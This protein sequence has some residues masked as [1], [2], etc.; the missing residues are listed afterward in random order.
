MIVRAPL[1]AMYASMAA[2]PGRVSHVVSTADGCGP[3]GLERGLESPRSTIL[4][5]H[6]SLPRSSSTSRFTAGARPGF[7]L[8]PVGNERN[9]SLIRQDGKEGRWCPKNSGQA[10]FWSATAVLPR[11][12]AWPTAL[13]IGLRRRISSQSNNAGCP[14]QTKRSGRRPA[15][16]RDPSASSEVVAETGGGQTS[17]GPR[18]GCG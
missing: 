11:P 1:L 14:W 5:R 6:F 12:G 7:E 17:R 4:S 8:Q 15:G 2:N 3:D 16:L 9:A 10:R 13:P 18:L